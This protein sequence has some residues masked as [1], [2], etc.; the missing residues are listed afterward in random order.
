MSCSSFEVLPREQLE[1][2]LAR[3]PADN[4]LIKGLSAR[5]RPPSILRMVFCPGASK[6]QNNVAGGFPLPSTRPRSQDGHA[7]KVCAYL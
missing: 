7:K 1:F 3:S 2:V 5:F 6:A 4:D